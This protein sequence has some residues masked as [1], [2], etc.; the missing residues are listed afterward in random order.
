MN[1]NILFCQLERMAR[2]NATRSSPQSSERVPV[3]AAR[4]APNNS[5]GL[6][7]QQQG[8]YQD[9]PFACRDCGRAQVWT[10]RQQKWWFEVARGSVYGKPVRCRS[11]RQ[12]ERARQTAARRVQLQGVTVKPIRPDR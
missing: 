3:D 1:E 4:L 11:C 2:R 6:D 8:Y 5:N 9:K 7:F 10:A 12:R